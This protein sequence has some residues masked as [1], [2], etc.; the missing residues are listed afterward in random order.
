[1]YKV[2]IVDDEFEAAEKLMECFAAYT[3]EYGVE[4]NTTHFKNGL[5]FIDEYTTDFDMVFMDIDMPLMNGLKTSKELRK[6]DSSVV[7]IFVTFLAKYAI[8]GYEVGALDYVLKPVNYNSF[9]IKLDRAI[10]NCTH[11]KRTEVILP[12]AQGEVCL[13]LDA[14]KYVEV[15]DHDLIYHTS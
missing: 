12:S 5:N 13:Q 10:Q 11:K 9:K 1:M 4:F 2:A 6:I 14:L 15:S 8:K 7:L 3:K